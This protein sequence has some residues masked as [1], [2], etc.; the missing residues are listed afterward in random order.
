[1]VF[2]VTTLKDRFEGCLL[3]LAVA[4][5]LGGRFEAQ[6]ADAILARFSSVDQL[7][8]YP[9]DEIWYTDDTQMAIGVAE[10][11]VADGQVIEEHLC[12]AF[13]ANYVPSRGYGRG[14]RAVLE[15]MGG[16][17]DHREVAERY[18]PGGSFG[19]GAAMRVAPVGLLFRD[20]RV[21]LWE[22]A[23]LSALPT[24][25][26][27]LGIEGAQ[28]LALAVALCSHLDCLDRATF[29]ADLLSAC[30]SREYRDNIEEACRVESPE[31]LAALGNRIE[32]LH[33]VPTAIA[34]FG[35]TPESY[36]ETIGNVILLGGDTDTLAAMAGALSGAYL[37]VGRIPS[38]L[39]GLLER[40]PKGGAY[41]TCCYRGNCWRFIGARRASEYAQW[42]SDYTGVPRKSNPCKGGTAFGGLREHAE[43]VSHLGKLEGSWDSCED[44]PASGQ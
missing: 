2:A 11:L 26:H 41:L 30:E 38:R 24:H 31:Q 13:V 6:S 21:K 12:Q 4:D 5:A 39:L 35:L 23:R 44:S 8:A 32:A 29:C 27:P 33:S 22:Q 1:M 18:F 16:W 7:I 15:A 40:S 20:D 17:R 42:G 37:G 9:Q 19:N 3:G 28:L 34:S 25:L 36:E 14:A 43:R 10:S